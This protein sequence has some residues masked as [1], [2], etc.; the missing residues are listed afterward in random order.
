MFLRGSLLL[1]VIAS[2]R[3]WSWRTVPSNSLRLNSTTY[4]LGT[5]EALQTGDDFRNLAVTL[6]LMHS[7]RRNIPTK[8][9]PYF[10]L[11]FRSLARR[12]S[13]YKEYIICLSW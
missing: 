3:T 2:T 4:K 8:Y 12:M 5:V 7:R 11:L 6:I 1:S 9:R 13:Y 10:R